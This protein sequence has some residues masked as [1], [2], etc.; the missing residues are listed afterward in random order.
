MNGV[1]ARNNRGRN[2]LLNIEISLRR[3]FA[4]EGDGHI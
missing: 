4:R 3:R 2:D 1:G